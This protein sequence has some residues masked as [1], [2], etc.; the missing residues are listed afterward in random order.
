[1]TKHSL[2]LAGKVQQFKAMTH[3]SVSATARR[4]GLEWH[5][6]VRLLSACE[7][8]Q[9]KRW[10]KTPSVA[11]TRRRRCVY[12]LACRV[13]KRGNHEFAVYPSAEAI[14][15]E[16]VEKGFLCS[17][18]TVLRDLHLLGFKCR[19]R[20]RVPVNDPEIHRRRLS[21]AKEQLRKPR[22]HF[23]HLVFSD[24]HVL[25]TNDNSHRQQWVR[26][27]DRVLPRERKR[28]QCVPRVAVW[29]AIGVGFKSHLV[30][31]PQHNTEGEA[32]RLTADSYVRRCL[33]TVAKQLITGNRVFQ[34]DGARPHIASQVG[35]YLER[36]EIKVLKHWPP[37]SPDLN[38]I[39]EL[40]SLMNARVADEHPTT[41]QE[42]EACAAKVWNRFAQNELDRFASSF[43]A[44]LLKCRAEHGRC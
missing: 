37:Y 32:F 41:Q 26:N 27:C 29:G 33:S 13:A 16:L 7:N 42:L 18:S 1:M 19:V 38:P 40:W 36:K 44:K 6:C 10:S 14:R 34:H 30:I 20:K 35:L 17:H 22:S 24:E 11:A 2:L 23:A 31:L 3:S 8:P 12:K 28:V 25:S 9:P 15:R 21:F 4:F 43:E 39:E 5:A